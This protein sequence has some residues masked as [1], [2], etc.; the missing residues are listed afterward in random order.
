MNSIGPQRFTRVL[1]NHINNLM[2]LAREPAQ[3]RWKYFMVAVH[4]IWMCLRRAT[5]TWDY[6]KV[7]FWDT[8]YRMR[9]FL[10]LT[11]GFQQ[12]PRN[13]NACPSSGNS[14]ELLRSSIHRKSIKID[15]H[16]K[17]NTTKTTASQARIKYLVVLVEMTEAYKIRLLNMIGQLLNSRKQIKWIA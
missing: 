3:K 11:D 17:K 10:C 2:M 16:E 9:P 8:A 12:Q 4:A 1:C 15:E 6:N 13:N 7:C 14:K 5:P